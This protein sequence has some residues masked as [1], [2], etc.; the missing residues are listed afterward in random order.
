MV[1][2]TDPRGMFIIGIGL[3]TMLLGVLVM[4]KMVK[5]EI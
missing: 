4:A 5:F 1:L 3:T 2:F